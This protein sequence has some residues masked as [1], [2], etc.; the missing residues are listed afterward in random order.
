MAGLPSVSAQALVVASPLHAVV[1][2]AGQMVAVLQPARAATQRLVTLPR[3]VRAGRARERSH[4]GA[5]RIGRFAA[6]A[7][8]LFDGPHQHGKAVSAFCDSAHN[9]IRR[10]QGVQRR[11][12]R[13]GAQRHQLY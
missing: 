3:S 6:R 10:P 12:N 11:S 9:A 7:A 5:S 2:H 1:P 13:D 4:S 8:Q